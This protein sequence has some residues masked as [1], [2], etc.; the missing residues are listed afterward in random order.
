[1]RSAGGR[2]HFPLTGMA[3]RSCVLV[4][5][6]CLAFAANAS[7]KKPL[8]RDRAFQEFVSSLW[9]LAEERGV[10]RKTFDRAFEGVTFDSTVIAQT[11][12]QAEFVEPIWQYLAAA[13]SPDRVSR[14]RDKAQSASAWLSKAGQEF[15]VDEGVIMA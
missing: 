1:M 8:E 14:G 9:P 3:L 4:L 13:A 15:G 10:A 5:A 7:A 6:A 11:T 2:R 12:R